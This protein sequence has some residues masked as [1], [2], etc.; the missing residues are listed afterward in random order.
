MTGKIAAGTFAD[1]HSAKAIFDLATGSK[2]LD[3]DVLDGVAVYFHDAGADLD[4][5][6][7]LHFEKID[8][9]VFV[10]GV[11][12]QHRP[13]GRQSTPTSAIDRINSS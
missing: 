12:N 6:G 4:L 7:S 9:L 8:D 13:L 1:S 2:I 5:P 10:I 11:G 3:P